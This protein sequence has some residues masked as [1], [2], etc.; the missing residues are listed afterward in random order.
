MTA[1]NKNAH[2]DGEEQAYFKQV[3]ARL[4]YFRKLRGYTDYEKFANQHDLSRSQYGQYEK[5]R[6][7]TLSTL[8]K[9]LRAMEVSTEEFFKGFKDS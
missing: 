8:R 1:G 7:L 4:R 6:N 3:G 9:I 5:G 2:A